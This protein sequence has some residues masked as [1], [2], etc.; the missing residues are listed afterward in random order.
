MGIPSRAG[1]PED[2]IP[3]YIHTGIGNSVD[4]AGINP[5][6][7]FAIRGADPEPLP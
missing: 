5:D 3:R 4:S 2:L 6:V 7:Y 1:R